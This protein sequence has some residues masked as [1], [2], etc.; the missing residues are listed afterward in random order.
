MFN[1]ENLK[2]K[3]IKVKTKIAFSELSHSYSPDR[4]QKMVDYFI[5]RE[6]E[7]N[8]EVYDIIKK[9]QK[10]NEYLEV[11]RLKIAE[12]NEEKNDNLEQLQEEFNSELKRLFNLF[13]KLR[14]TYN[15][16]TRSTHEAIFNLVDEVGLI[17]SSL[18]YEKFRKKS[19]EIIKQDN[20]LTFK[21]V[22]KNCIEI[23]FSGLISAKN[24]ERDY[25]LIQAIYD[26]LQEKYSQNNEI[27]R[28]H[29]QL[30][31]CFEQY[32]FNIHNKS[33]R[34]TDKIN[35]SGILNAIVQGVCWSDHS[36]CLNIF[37]QTY[38]IFPE[39]NEEYTKVLIM[40]P[41]EFFKNYISEKQK[42]NCINTSAKEPITT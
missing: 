31:V 20:K 36:D 42:N 14:C 21:V 34:D 16:T 32:V 6:T 40:T 1:P 29:E 19:D 5:K 38:T 12:E 18:N 11:L 13:L 8:K 30:Y 9:I 41:Q 26:G 35:F 17:S 10:K 25:L 7:I 3:G 22:N 28:E 39:E 4:F 27:L 24:Y 15:N 33:I 23:S 37:T 2:Y